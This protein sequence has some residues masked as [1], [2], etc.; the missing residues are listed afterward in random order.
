MLVVQL[1]VYV[2]KDLDCIIRINIFI[3]VTPKETL[4]TI[5]SFDAKFKAQNYFVSMKTLLFSY[6]KR[7]YNTRV[8]S[9][10][11]IDTPLQH[12]AHPSEVQ[13]KLGQTFH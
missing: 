8:D 7:T 3:E 6:L 1:Y 11:R 4:G 5:K 9:I 12:P 10:Q 13:N 2:Y